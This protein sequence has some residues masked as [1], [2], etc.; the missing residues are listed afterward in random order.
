MKV[1]EVVYS[2]TNTKEDE[3]ILIIKIFLNREIA[4]NY[5]KR[6]IKETKEEFKETKEYEIKETE[7]YYERTLNGK[8]LEDSIYIWLDEEELYDEYE[9]LME[10]K[11]LQNEKEKDYE[12]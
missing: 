9:L 6:Q 1:Y 11:R 10:R 12:M 5:L 4:L 3:D 7:N 2:K 8:I